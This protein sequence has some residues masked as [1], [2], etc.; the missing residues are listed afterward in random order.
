MTGNTTSSPRS[1]APGREVHLEPRPDAPLPRAHQRRDGVRAQVPAEL[2]VDAG[3]NDNDVP[4][5]DR[6]AASD[7][8]M[9]PPQKRRPSV[10]GQ[11]ADQSLLVDVHR[12]AEG[13]HI[14][15]LD[16]PEHRCLKVRQPF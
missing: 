2:V 4:D 14:D 12:D 7:R 1:N 11:S 9:V 6:L 10:D 15:C 16:P 8:V 3:A 5:E 13:R